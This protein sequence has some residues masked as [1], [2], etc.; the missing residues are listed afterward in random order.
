MIPL[1]EKGKPNESF[2]KM[3]LYLTNH[4]SCIGGTKG[5][6]HL[7]HLRSINLT[8]TMMKNNFP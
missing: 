7:L 6:R 5:Q 1:T 3:S 2:F 8:N 4:F